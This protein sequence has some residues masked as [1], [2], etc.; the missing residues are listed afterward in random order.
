MAAFRIFRRLRQLQDVDDTGIA[1]G[2]VPTFDTAVS[3]FTMAAPAAGA[4]HSVTLSGNTAGALAL[5]QT[6]TWTLAGGNNIT[7]SQA[8]NAVTISAG[9]AG[10]TFI[11]GISASD[12]L[13]TSGT[14]R[15]TG[16]GAVTVK[17]GTGQLVVIDA[18]AQSVQPE[19]QTFISG[20]SASDTLYTSGNVRLTGVGGGVTVSSNTGQRV[21]ISV[22]APVAQT[23]QTQNVVD[24]TLAGNTAGALALVSSGTATFAGGNN[25]TLSQNGNAITISGPN[26]GG[27]Q[28][29]ISGLANSET[30]YTSGTVSLSELGAVT[31]RSTTG[32]QFQIS[33]NSQSVQPET[34]TFIGGIRNS[35]TTYTSGTV[36]LSELGA[37]TIR[38][39][40]G[41]A[42]QL[43]VAAQSVQP[44]TQTFV[45]GVANSQTTY[46]SG[47][48]SLSELGAITI[49]ST[50]GNQ[51]Q[52]SVNSQTVQ[53][54]G[55]IAA[56]LSTGGNTA[57]DTGV[58]SGTRLVFVGTNNI[59]LSEGTAANATTITVSGPTTA[60]QTVQTQGILN[61]ALSNI[62]NTAG[63]TGIN[64]GTRYVLAG[65]NG[66]TLSGSSAANATTVTI[67]GV[68]QSVQTNDIPRLGVSTGGNTA[69]NTTVNSGTRFVLVGS[70][71][72]S[73]SQATAASASTITIDASNQN[74]S[75]GVST[76]GNTAGNTTVNTGSRFVLVGSNGITASAGTAAGAT[77]VTLSGITQSVQT[78]DI[79]NMGVST[80]GNTAGN[81]TVN[82]GTRFVLVGSNMISLS[83]TTGAS[84]TT[85]S[86]N[87]TQSV[88]TQGILN[89]ALSNIGNTAGDTGINS[90]TR[91]VLAGGNNITLSASTAANATTITISAPN[92]GAGAMSAG[93]STGGNT[94]GATGITG[95]QLVLVG[96]NMI[97]L[98][99]TTGANGGTVSINATQSVQTQGV[100]LM[101]VSTGG[102]TSGDTTVNS[103]TRFVLVGTNATLSQGTAANATTVTVSVPAT[104]SLSATGQ[105]QISTNGSTISIGAP[106]PALSYRWIENPV[107]LGVTQ[108]IGTSGASNTTVSAW[109]MPVS[110]PRD[111]A[112]N[113]LNLV[114][115]NSF[116]SATTSISS[117]RYSYSMGASVGFYSLTGSSMS[118]CTSFSHTLGYTNQTAAAVGNMSFTASAGWGGSGTS[119]T[120]QGG[121]N[122]SAI[123]GSI[124]GVKQ[125]PLNYS[126]VSNTLT[127]GQYWAVVAF[128]QLTGSVANASLTSVGYVS[129]YSAI[130]TALNPP[131]LFGDSASLT[132]PYPFL[133]MATL[134]NSSNSLMP[135]SFNTSKITTATATANSSAFQS[136]WMNIYSSHGT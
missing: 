104:S 66:I 21:D 120:T 22:A 4:A 30:T 52:L 135:V 20:I 75:I 92:L 118:L 7:L 5:I 133:G 3:K 88:Q 42:F 86:I 132:S 108:G 124:Q 41:N 6:G 32:N 134:V 48:V 101:G 28:T 39:T 61:V 93:V 67:S 71:L 114:V 24:L 50:T 10:Q 8:G 115:Q 96:T 94:A 18:P 89:V 119:K 43:S 62:G 128:S 37:I 27:A 76:G 91:M 16:S 90:G 11:G 58:A 23:V 110:L 127:R 129:N 97:S 46:T 107:Q 77:T 72:V 35:E 29:G 131:V 19:T 47:T 122:L 25:I 84:A 99:Q 79:P 57:G 68:T 106:N 87:A 26:V 74:L 64:S 15:L 126:T 36:R 31:I 80:G 136:I 44:E 38:S 100:P 33:V 40:T 70:N 34:Q 45:G 54:Q 13:Y 53:T 49:R 63:D 111:L 130:G 116:S 98:S 112:F 51:Y 55:I 9:A 2:D 1:Q 85:I 121:A 65:G 81:T 95:T 109:V 117:V 105:V 125:I 59:T 12:T 82:S 60:A 14:V 113:N 56:G 103:G 73:L 69:G 123:M 83:Q 17:S 102:A 78:N